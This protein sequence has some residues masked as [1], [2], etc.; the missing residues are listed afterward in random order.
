MPFLTRATLCPSKANASPNQNHKHFNPKHNYMAKVSRGYVVEQFIICCGA[1]SVLILVTIQYFLAWK[2]SQNLHKI[3][4]FHKLVLLSLLGFG[5][6]ESIWS[7][8]PRGIWGLYSPFTVSLLRDWIILALMQSAFFWG[9]LVIR[10]IA[11]FVKVVQKYDQIPIWVTSTTPIII[12]V[13]LSGSLS[14]RAAQTNNLL[15]RV[16]F[17]FCLAIFICL[18]AVYILVCLFFIR[19]ALIQAR[20]SGVEGNSTRTMIFSE[21]YKKLFRTGTIFALLAVAG[22]LFS[23]ANF[24]WMKQGNDFTS[25]V[26][27]QDSAV[28]MPY[29]FYLV[30]IALGAAV[31]Y[32]VWLPLNSSPQTD[33][34]RSP[35][36]RNIA[37][38]AKGNTSE[39]S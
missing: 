5:V 12:L 32:A 6:L 20:L 23:F 33:V 21:K 24:V 28:Y 34:P 18:F 29:F 36:H 7:V 25:G 9:D 16:I 30:H 13:I 10:S 26:L 31:F 1:I 15:Y 14:W 8:D 35:S 37:S 38:T 27:V 11:P 19:N 17:T 39:N 22:L 2:M 3:Q 4:L